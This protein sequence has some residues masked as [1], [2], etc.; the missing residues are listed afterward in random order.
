MNTMP[1]LITP[2][3]Q[4]RSDP[5]AGWV[6]VAGGVLLAASAFLPWAYAFQAL[7]GM[8]LFGYPSPLQIFGMVLGLLVAGLIMCSR[9]I[10]PR[11][12]IQ[13]G[14]VRGA[15]AAGVGALVF[16]IL[17]IAAIALE[18]GGLVNV[19]WGGWI[20][21]VGTLLA[22]MGTRFMVADKTPTLERVTL[23]AWLEIL[24]VAVVM[25]GVLFASAYALN[26]S[27]GGAFV[28]F[29]AFLGTVI[30]VMI[31][32]GAMGWL[33]AVSRRHRQVLILAAFLVAF[34]FPFTQHGSDAN[35][36]IATQ[37]LIF[38]A[39]AMGLNIVVGLAG[40]LDLGYIAF[41]GAGAFTAAVLSKSA[42]STV[43]FHP[44]FLV[45][46]LIS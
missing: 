32:T 40:L 39:T 36:S 46:A 13:V 21:L 41:L 3:R 5:A 24:A 14:W 4:Q 15:K 8:S 23:P 27:D 1:R 11:S 37:I 33:S 2:E 31:R 19:V 17:V 35:M 42:F 26:L 34:L 25:A 6:G 29:L 43:N 16:M 30:A 45:V 9:L 12:K 18:L 10:K 7:D 22:F 44:P 20:A 28:A 38:A